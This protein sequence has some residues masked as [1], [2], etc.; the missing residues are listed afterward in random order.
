MTPLALHLFPV[1]AMMRL[2]V[3]AGWNQSAADWRRVL[4]L[5][6]EFCW[7][8]ELN[9]QLVATATAI[10]YEG[11]W[12][13]IGMVLTLPEY[14]GRG[15]ARRL[16]G[17]LLDL[18][19]ARGIK[20]IGL[21]ATAMGA[22]LYAEFGFVAEQPIERWVREGERMAMPKTGVTIAACRGE[23]LL[24]GLCH[25]SAGWQLEDGSF[26]LLRAGEVAAYLGPIQASGVLAARELVSKIPTVGAV[27]WDLLPQHEEAA[28]LA[29]ELGFARARSLVRMKMGGVWY[30]LEPRRQYAIAGFEYG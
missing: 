5:S 16:V 24:R 13:W 11:E 19:E 17:V 30:G 25:D 8:I 6:P 28:R 22:P 4:G 29:F 2:S 18:L 10:V 14:R 20:K 15:L 1:D 7:G 21:D 12:A 9:G 27:Y 26:A 3:A 23:A